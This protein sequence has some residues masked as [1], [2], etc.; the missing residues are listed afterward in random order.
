LLGLAGA[1]VGGLVVHLANL[2][3][4][5]GPVL[6]RYEELLFALLGAIVLVVLAKLLRRSS[7]KAPAS[8]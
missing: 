4:G 3:F 1:F 6:I 7:T 2:D 8:K 5:W